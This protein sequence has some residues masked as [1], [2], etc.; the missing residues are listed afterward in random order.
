MK[1]SG[2]TDISYVNTTSEK[3]PEYDKWQAFIDEKNKEAPPSLKTFRQ[4]M[5]FWSQMPTERAFVKNAVQ[6]IFISVLF[7]FIIL[8]I[9]TKNWV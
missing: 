7:S 2:R 3:Q 5:Q 1:F 6:G 4:S 8:L 9:A